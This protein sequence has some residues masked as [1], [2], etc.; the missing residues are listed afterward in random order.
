MTSTTTPA[1]QLLAVFDGEADAEKVCREFAAQWPTP[2]VAAAMV[3]GESGRLPWS[4][5]AGLFE[6]VL[7]AT[8]AEVAA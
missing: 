8:I 2:S 7:R 6:R 5:I 4:K 3:H 1:E